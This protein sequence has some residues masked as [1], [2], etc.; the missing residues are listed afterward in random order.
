LIASLRLLLTLPALAQGLPTQVAGDNSDWWSIIFRESKQIPLY[1]LDNMEPSPSNFRILGIELGYDHMFENVAAKLGTT[2]EII[3]GDASSSR[4]QTCYT[5]AGHPGAAYLIFET[6]EVELSLYLFAEGAPWDARDRCA[7]SDLVSPKLQTDSGLRLGQ[8]RSE[9]RAI[10]GKPSFSS[11]DR[12]IY[13]NMAQKKTPEESL[14]RFRKQ[15]TNMTD[16]DFHDS[17]D[18]Y[19]L[20]TYIEVRFTGQ[21]ATYFGI[22]KSEVY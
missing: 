16:K 8:T 22:L 6:G 4:S 9:I 17:Y 7:K 3:R 21:K 1:K 19:T 20:S 12:L 5:S 15:D 14:K 11:S 13:W 2:A 10:L 18:F